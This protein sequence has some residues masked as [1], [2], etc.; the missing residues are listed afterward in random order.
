MCKV[1]VPIRQDGEVIKADQEELLGTVND[2]PNR[3]PTE[4]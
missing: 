3:G 2:S 1:I 4:G